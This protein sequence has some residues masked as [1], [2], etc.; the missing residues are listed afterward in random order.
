M[1]LVPLVVWIKAK[2]LINSYKYIYIYLVPG[3]RSHISI[4]KIRREKK[5][6]LDRFLYALWNAFLLY[7]MT[8]Y[9]R[10]PKWIF[11]F[12][13]FILIFFLYIF[14]III[15]SII[16]EIVRTV[17]WWLHIFFDS[18]TLHN[19]TVD[20]IYIFF[21][22]FNNKDK[23]IIVITQYNFMPNFFFYMFFNNIVDEMYFSVY[24]KCI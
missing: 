1:S 5:K 11:F 8:I 6:A 13:I 15:I 14:F 18:Y 24:A 19:S 2:Y 10:G 3:F 4:K 21:F 17:Q 7:Y 20:N 22:I 16:I 9:R 23:K 12:M